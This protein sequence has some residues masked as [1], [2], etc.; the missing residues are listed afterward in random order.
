MSKKSV[1]RP[2]TY[3]PEQIEQLWHDYKIKR[4]NNTIVTTDFTSRGERHVTSTVSKPL[5]YTIIG[6]IAFIG[7]S[8]Q[9]WNEYYKSHPLYVE[10]VS[11]IYGEAEASLVDGF[12][13]G[14]ADTRVSGLILSQYD[15][16]LPAQQQDD[17]GIAEAI[18]KLDE[19]LNKITIGTGD[20][21]NTDKQAD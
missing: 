15:Y 3:T 5:P 6:F 12:I 14:Q 9:A 2:R 7:L 4:D 18:N 19:V 10:Q 11:R 16:K 8:K 20:T 1:G 17:S 21:D 13:S